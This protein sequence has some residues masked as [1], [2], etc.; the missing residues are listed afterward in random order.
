MIKYT[1]PL[2]HFVEDNGPEL[3]LSLIVL[4][5]LSSNNA[6]IIWKNQGAF[7]IIPPHRIHNHWA[8]IQCGIKQ[9]EFYSRNQIPTLPFYWEQGIDISPKV[10]EVLQSEVFADHIL[11]ALK[12]HLPPS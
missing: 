4:T 8:N 10:V 12:E 1:R 2:I 11:N 7:R 9:K 5:R 6:V 3:N